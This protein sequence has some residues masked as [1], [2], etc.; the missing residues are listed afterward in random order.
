MDDNLYELRSDLGVFS[1]PALMLRAGG[2]A[3][4][5][6]LELEDSGLRNR[7]RQFYRL[8]EDTATRIKDLV[9]NVF[10][11]KETAE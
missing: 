10:R 7:T 1:V 3:E 8:S 6:E 5:I 11:D 2:A 9:V 4:K